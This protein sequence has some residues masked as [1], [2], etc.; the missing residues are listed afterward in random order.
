M[1]PSGLPNL[2]NSCCYLNVVVQVLKSVPDF[3]SKIEQHATT[4]ECMDDEC[5]RCILWHCFNGYNEEL[6]HLISDIIPGARMTDQQ[7]AEEF[8]RG[9]L[10]KVSG[11][12]P[13]LLDMFQSTWNESTSCVK[14]SEKRTRGT[15]IPIVSL[16]CLDRKF[17]PVVDILESLKMEVMQ[18]KINFHCGCGSTQALQEKKL[19]FPS[20]GKYFILHLKRENF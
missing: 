5:I 16:S 1:V 20:S 11:E 17:E 6:Y 13:S 10:T 14:C 2:N 18:E 8:L 4:V 3:L 19:C 12:D 7:D 9:L 15:S